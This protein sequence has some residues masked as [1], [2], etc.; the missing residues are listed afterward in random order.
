MKISITIPDYRRCAVTFLVPSKENG[1]IDNLNTHHNL[2][3]FLTFLRKYL[4][5]DQDGYNGC[6][7][8]SVSSASCC[9]E[10]EDNV[11][12]ITRGTKITF[13]IRN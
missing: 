13:Q 9:D 8:A 7:D 10:A 6:S 5:Q 2:V 1:T 4:Y 12:G 11:T 3:R